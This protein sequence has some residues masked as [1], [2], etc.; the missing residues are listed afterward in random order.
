MY[1]DV[2][3]VEIVDA[4][5]YKIRVFFQDGLMGE[6]KFELNFFRGVFSHL[7]DPVAFAKV[8]VFDNVVTWPGHLDL[9]PDAMW[10]GI[11]NNN[12]LWIVN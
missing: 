7:V 1:W 8:V 3:K 11:K 10:H 6:V 12:G 5:D 4:Y 2:I 9:A